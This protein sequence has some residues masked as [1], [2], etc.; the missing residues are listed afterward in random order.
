MKKPYEKPMCAI[1]TLEVSE[2]IANCD[3]AVGFAD[4]NK[5]C[6]VNVGGVT[7]FHSY[8]H[9]NISNKG[10]RFDKFCYHIPSGVSSFFQS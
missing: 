10:D 8:C 1:E 9:Y 3:K 7:I 5:S 6:K 4:G 2:S